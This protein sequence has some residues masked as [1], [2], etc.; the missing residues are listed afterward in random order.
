MGQQRNREQMPG[1]IQELRSR[2]E[3]YTRQGAVLDLQGQPE[4]AAGLYLQALRLHDRLLE[5]TGDPAFAR[6]AGEDCL[7]LADLSMQ[8]G[9]LHGADV[10]YVRAMGYGPGR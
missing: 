8:L 1:D 10:Y 3:E 9:N 5:M 2:A 6:A 4:Q 7:S